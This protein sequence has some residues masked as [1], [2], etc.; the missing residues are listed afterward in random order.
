MVISVAL[1][2]SWARTRP[3]T[4]AKAIS[5]ASI[6]QISASRC[7]IEHD[8][9]TLSHN[10]NLTYFVHDHLV[11]K[12]RGPYLESFPVCCHLDDV[13]KIDEIMNARPSSI[14]NMWTLSSDV[15]YHL[16]D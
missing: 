2:T 12:T 6:A 13:C 15:P 4:T 16:G 7:T 9:L 5:S 11:H 3:G 8:M 1:Y 10:L 14:I